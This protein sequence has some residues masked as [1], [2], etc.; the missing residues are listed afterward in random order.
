VKNANKNRKMKRNILIILVLLLIAQACSLKF[1]RPNGVFKNTPSRKGGFISSIKFMSDTTFSY[2]ESGH[3][4]Y[5]ETK[6]KYSILNEKIYLN[7]YLKYKE[8][9][10]KLIN[11][12][13]D[14]DSL[15]NNVS[16][17]IRDY[18][19]IKLGYAIAFCNQE[20]QF[21]DMNGNIKFNSGEDSTIVIFFLD[22]KFKLP[23]I[24]K[25]IFC[26]DLYVGLLGSDNHYFE[27][28]ECIIQRRNKL[29]INGKTFLKVNKKE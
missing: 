17:T 18:D 28:K 25:T 11:K 29:I 1:T 23:I 22:N 19:S 3:S 15:I 9:M 20:N 6:G 27:N 8:G 5:V 7:S 4:H 10:Y 14:N 16:L 26:Y 12:K 24:P 21:A 13:C 2:Y